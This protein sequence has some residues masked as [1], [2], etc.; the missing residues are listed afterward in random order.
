MAFWEVDVLLV[1][2]SFV[3]ASAAE[4]QEWEELHQCSNI[5]G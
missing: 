4:L 1:A 3:A 5:R 2:A